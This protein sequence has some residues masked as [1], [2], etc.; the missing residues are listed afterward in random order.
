ML[1]SFVVVTT[2]SG[3]RSGNR[4][5]LFSC[6]ALGP[7]GERRCLLALVGRPESHGR[8][9][10]LADWQFRRAGGALRELVLVRAAEAGCSDRQRDSAGV[11]DRHGLLLAAGVA[12]HLAERAGVRRNAELGLH[13]CARHGLGA[14]VLVLRRDA[15]VGGLLTR[16]GGFETDVDAAL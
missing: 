13:A 4:D 8:R 2:T 16:R 11:L 5:F 7:D 9:A 6:A 1:P 3:S 14:K 10:G 15:Q 12:L